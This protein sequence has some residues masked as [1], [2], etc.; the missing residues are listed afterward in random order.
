[1]LAYLN[2]NDRSQFTDMMDELHRSARVEWVSNEGVGV[3]SGNDVTD[4][5]DGRFVLTHNHR[6]VALTGLTVRPWP[7]LASSRFYR[8]SLRKR[9][10][11]GCEAKFCPGMLRA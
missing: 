10:L 11:G 4:P 1:M 5:S 3:V 7:G 9:S 8:D 2:P 6:P